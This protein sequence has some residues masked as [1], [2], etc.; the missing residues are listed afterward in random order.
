MQQAN[1][2]CGG[3]KACAVESKRIQQSNAPVTV[4][5]EVKR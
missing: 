2:A 4:P 1:A 3:I 5:D